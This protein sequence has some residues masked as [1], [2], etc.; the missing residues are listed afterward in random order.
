MRR[1]VAVFQGKRSDKSDAGSSV[2]NGRSDRSQATTVSNPSQTTAKSRSG[3]FRSLSKGSSSQLDAKGRKHA[4]PPVSTLPDH[5]GSS[6]SS[7]SGGPRTPSDDHESAVHIGQGRRSWLAQMSDTSLSVVPSKPMS[8]SYLPQQF[9]RESDQASETSSESDD[10]DEQETQP[11]TSL[12]QG[13]PSLPIAPTVY[14]RSITEN[15]LR[16]PFYPPPL[17]HVPNAPLFPRSCNS[18]RQLPPSDSLYARVLRKRLLGRLDS[19]HEG[20]LKGFAS[21]TR[22]PQRRSLVL[23]DIAIPKTARVLPTS[24]GLR[25]WIERPCFE[26]RLVV[27]LPAEVNGDELRC[28]RV[29]ASAA[30]EALGYS[31]VLETLAGFTDDITSPPPPG[32]AEPQSAPPTPLFSLTSSSS[33]LSSAPPSPAQPL[34]SP[35]SPSPPAVTSKVLPNGMF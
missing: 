5:V 12:S 15:A 26:D 7:S 18:S 25:R 23:D 32:T 35:A 3:F 28:E 31:E 10:A 20:E 11:P 6:A 24:P 1:L 30:V 21:R 9:S 16:P 22:T 4:M 13:S 27:L 19:Q 17:L 8:R 34:P 14:F 29:S 33:S 2:S